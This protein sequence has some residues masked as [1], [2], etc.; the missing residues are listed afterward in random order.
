MAPPAINTVVCIGIRAA[1][2]VAMAMSAVV[3]MGVCDGAD[4]R[5]VISASL[6]S[7][8]SN[9]DGGYFGRA[10]ASAARANMENTEPFMMLVFAIRADKAGSCRRVSSLSVSVKC[11]EWRLE[12]KNDSS[13][14]KFA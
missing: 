10:M 8:M 11:R 13:L 14:K 6:M 4:G 2:C 1:F 5:L 3:C 12:E 7:S 9:R